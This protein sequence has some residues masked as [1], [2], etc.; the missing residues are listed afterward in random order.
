[1]AVDY[2]E[3]VVEPLGNGLTAASGS[4]S[5]TP[6]SLKWDCSIGGLDFLFATSKENP[7]RR[8]TSK[9]R[10]ERIDTQRDP[11]ENSL[12]SGLWVRS[13]A[14]WHY[15]AGLSSRRTAGDRCRQRQ[16]SVTLRVAGLTRG[17]RGS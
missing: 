4:G 16:G 17:L 3:D 14:S 13:Q 6:E 9:F 5:F 10:R 8:E 2:T 1:M 11:G 7:M 12:D 15:G